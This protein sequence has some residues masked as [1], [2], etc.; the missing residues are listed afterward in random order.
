[1]G[2]YKPLRATLNRFIYKIT[3]IRS[4]KDDMCVLVKEFVVSAVLSRF[5]ALSSEVFVPLREER[6]FG[7][8]R[9]KRPFAHFLTLVT[10][11]PLF[12]KR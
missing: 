10:D 11:G 8:G 2:M 7:R 6:R 1:M 4:Q 3:E 9:G 12:L 5:Y